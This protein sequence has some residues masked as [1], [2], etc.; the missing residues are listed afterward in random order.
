MSFYSAIEDG[1][2][3]I[4]AIHVPHAGRDG[5]RR[6]HTGPSYAKHSQLG[7]HVF[8]RGVVCRGFGLSILG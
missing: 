7:C 3:Q 8:T 4:P 1:V 6:A 5:H 2:W